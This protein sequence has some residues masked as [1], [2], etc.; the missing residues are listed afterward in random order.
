VAKQEVL[1]EIKEFREAFNK[2]KP[3]QFYFGDFVRD[4]SPD[5]TCGS[6]CCLWGWIPQIAPEIATRYNLYYD[7]FSISDMSESPNVLRWPK[8]ISSYLFCPH[9]HLLD[10]KRL[11]ADTSLPMVLKAW[12]EVIST[13]EKTNFLDDLF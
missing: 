5:R 10:F 1:L 6:I 4:Y 3:E 12:D 9:K 7:F 8:K 11:D 2:I 13:L